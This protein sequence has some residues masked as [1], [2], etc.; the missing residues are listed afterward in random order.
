V[1]YKAFIQHIDRTLLPLPFEWCPIPA[2]KVMLEERTLEVLPFWMAKYPITYSQFQVFVEAEDGFKDPR[3]W[4]GLRSDDDHKKQPGEP[5]W[6]IDT[7]PREMVSWYD[8]IAFCQWLNSRLSLPPIPA[9]MTIEALAAY[10]GIRLPTEWEWQ[11]AAQ[12]SD[13]RTYPY[14]SQ[15]DPTRG[16]TQ[17]TGAGKTTPVDSYPEG[18]SPFGVLDMSGNVSEWCLNELDKP[19]DVDLS[20]NVPRALRGGSWDA[21]QDFARISTTDGNFPA[22]RNNLNGIRICV[23]NP[24]AG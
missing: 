1:T 22:T 21:S 5:A 4:Q 19:A 2:G 6:Q 24:S 12:G 14:G 13:G 3:W 9:N 7:H 17:E 20:R 23:G 16:N 10:T 8:A 15:F 11:W 18:A